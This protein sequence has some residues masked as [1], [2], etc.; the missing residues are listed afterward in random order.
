MT[1]PAPEKPF[2]EE[3][4]HLQQLLLGK[5]AIFREI[6]RVEWCISHELWYHVLT[7]PLRILVPLAL[8]RT[9]F[10]CHDSAPFNASWFRRRAECSLPS[11]RG[12]FE[13]LPSLPAEPSFWLPEDFEANTTAAADGWVSCLDLEDPV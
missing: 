11:L 4:G 8:H 9:A 2:Q 5:Q 7:N 13:S 10:Q 3:V 6:G 1:R 12:E